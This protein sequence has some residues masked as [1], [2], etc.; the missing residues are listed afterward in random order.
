M[1]AFRVV[2]GPLDTLAKSELTFKFGE[3]GVLGGQVD[4]KSGRS[5]FIKLSL[6]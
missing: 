3:V 4:W 2:L 6:F 1:N 5:L